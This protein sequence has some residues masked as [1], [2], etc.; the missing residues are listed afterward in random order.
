MKSFKYALLALLLLQGCAAPD[1]S[2]KGQ[3]EAWNRIYKESK[4]HK[5]K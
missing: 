3:T 1:Y 5:A 2:L 4:E